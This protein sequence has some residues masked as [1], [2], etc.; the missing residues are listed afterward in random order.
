MFEV[1]SLKIGELV[2]IQVRKGI[3]ADR[4]ASVV[5][6][7]FD[8]DGPNEPGRVL[9][10]FVVGVHR[11]GQ[12]ELTYVEISPTLEPLGSELGGFNVYRGAIHKIERI[13]F[14]PPLFSC[15]RVHFRGGT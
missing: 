10:G 12:N 2:V 3:E 9:A 5:P 13:A 15:G 1:T 14:V 8:D 11:A 7:F 4:S 6:C